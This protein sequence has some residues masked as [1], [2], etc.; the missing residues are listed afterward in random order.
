MLPEKLPPANDET[1]R[2]VLVILVWVTLNWVAVALFYREPPSSMRDLLIALVGSLSTVFIQQIQ[3]Y[4]KTGV[5]N[6]RQ[7][8]DSINKMASVAAAAT[9]DTGKTIPLNPGD[10]VTVAA[11]DNP[12]E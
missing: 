5:S 9:P 11:H 10:K 7:K 6:D 12:S 4:N 2:F 1:A 3:Y 8:D